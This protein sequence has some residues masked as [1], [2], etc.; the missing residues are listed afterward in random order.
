MVLLLLLLALAPGVLLM[1]YIIYM[2][3]NEPE[4]IGFVIFII[5]M[6]AVSC[7][8]AA[9]IESFLLTIPL[10]HM[11]GIIGAGLQSFLVI[12][13]TE[14]FVKLAVVLIFVWKNRNFNEENDGIVYVGAAALGFAMFENIFYVTQH[15]FGT[16]IARALLAVPLHCFS[17]VLMG[18]FVGLARFTEN[19]KK[20]RSLILKGFLLAVLFHAVYDTFA[21]SAS[22]ISLLIIPVT[23]ILI[24]MGIL[25]LNKG[26]ILSQKRWQNPDAAS[27]PA[28][29]RRKGRI[30]LKKIDPYTRYR[31]DLIGIDETGRYYLKPRKRTALFV[32]S[33][34]LMFICLLIGVLFVNI[35]I[36]DVPANAPEQI[37][38]DEFK[39]KFY[40][41]VLD[42]EDTLFI[43][44]HYSIYLPESISPGDFNYL[45]LDNN[46]IELV[47]RY[48]TEE[49]LESGL[50]LY[51]LASE[52][53]AE[54]R[55]L[56][57]FA[58]LQTDLEFN[59]NLILDRKTS[60][61]NELVILTILK[62]SGVY[63]TIP[64]ALMATLIVCF[65][66]ILIILFLEI[67]WI[68]ARRIR[69]LPEKYQ[70]EQ[71]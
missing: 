59:R 9:F 42:Q 7:L 27:K 70:G 16:G 21:L 68:R 18:Y 24:V 45:S 52:M 51:R 56:L 26:R 8:P 13:P 5:A 30:A 31:R 14:E 1:W 50:Y 58:L 23:I 25:F 37:P 34:V 22:S 20:R 67:S 65:I 17:G 41:S 63:F 11:G 46:D 64:E 62:D 44:D 33:K 6:G 4:P 15:G 32:I 35:A 55:L 61:E 28:R 12:A 19:R 2:D 3:R 71:G 29:V 40:Y 10:F 60:R 38:L 66:P 47:K 48:Y 43:L 54:Q 69:Y 53:E 36:D 49:T 39:S 57:S